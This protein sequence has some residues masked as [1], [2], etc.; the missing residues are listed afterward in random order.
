TYDVRLT[1]R[2]VLQPRLET[3]FAFQEVE[4]FGMGQGFDF[5]G[6]SARLRYEIR[7]ELAPYVGVRWSRKLGETADIARSE[8]EDV[9]NLAF[10]A[11]IRFWF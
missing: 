5:V 3:L 2:L 1:Q 10:V 6:L 8:G 7:R 9:E 4:K 11:G